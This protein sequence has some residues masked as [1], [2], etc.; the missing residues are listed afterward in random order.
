MTLYLTD[1]TSAAENREREGIGLRSRGQVLPRRRDDELGLGV[2]SLER[3]Y[4]A[5]AR[6]SSKV[7][8]CRCTEK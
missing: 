5:L 8:C 4:P 7:S 3:V 6:W 2:T 1:N